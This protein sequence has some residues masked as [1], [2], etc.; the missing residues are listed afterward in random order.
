MNLLKITP[1]IIFI[2]LFGCK[3]QK[4]LKVVGGGTAWAVGTFNSDGQRI[5]F[6]A[7]S[8]TG[9]PILYSGGPESDIM[10]TGGKP[11]CVSC[12]GIDASGGRHIQG[13][14]RM[15]A[16]DIRW[17]AL[18]KMKQK[19]LLKEGKDTANVEYTLAD[20]KKE[21]IDG[22]ELDGDKLDEDM[23]RWKMNND[24]LTLLMKY[25]KSPYLQ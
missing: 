25:L 19:Q 24:D 14:I 23:P 11:A 22:R 20:F 8:I 3:H 4:E 1:L 16:P 5:F 9:S 18:T 6:T 15:D 2:T 13:D 21:V 17:S 10:L 12:H 7:T